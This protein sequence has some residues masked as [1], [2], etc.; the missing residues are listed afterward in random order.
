MQNDS[1]TSYT[2]YFYCK[3]ENMILPLY[4]EKESLE[5]LKAA[6][7]NK[8]SAES[9]TH[10]LIR[11]TIACLGANVTEIIINDYTDDVYYSYIRLSRGTDVF[12]INA[13]LVDALCIGLIYNCSI[14]VNSK[15]L[16]LYGIK[17]TRDLLSKSLA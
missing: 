3:A 10:D 7:K 14:S 16:E 13:N 15:I 5:K 1:L 6:Q 9:N 4:L 17:I 8:P 12:D 11:R 2:A